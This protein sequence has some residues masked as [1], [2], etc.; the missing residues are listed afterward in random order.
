MEVDSGRVFEFELFLLVLFWFLAFL[1]S[2]LSFYL[3][4]RFSC[5]LLGL[6][7]FLLLDDLLDLFLVFD[8]LAVLHGVLDSRFKLCAF[9][10][11]WINQGRD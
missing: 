11:Q 6:R 1:S 10:C 9:C 5:L 2:S 4:Y 3:V 7:F 8:L